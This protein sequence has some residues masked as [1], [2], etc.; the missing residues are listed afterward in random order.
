MRA[1]SK[2]KDGG[3]LKPGS[4]TSTKEL[5]LIPRMPDM[6]G[7][8]PLLLADLSDEMSYPSLHL[9]TSVSAEVVRGSEQAL[10]LFRM[11]VGATLVCWLAD[12]NDP[13]I[14][15]V[16]NGW[17]KSAYMFVALKTSAGV[18]VRTGLV[19]GVPPAIRH[20]Y[21]SSGPLDNERF[22]RSTIEAVNSGLIKAQVK[23]DIDSVKKI[24]KV[25][26]F[27]ILGKG[28][29]AA[30]AAAPGRTA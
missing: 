10:Y 20:I 23:S 21:D 7:T 30:Q 9:E 17:A 12:P 16:L 14:H 3:N 22:I 25:R 18:M 19:C 11:Q 29:Q 5:R 28:A 15:C 27:S 13:E 24:R 6:T 1:T 2:V 26:V 8:C 4:I